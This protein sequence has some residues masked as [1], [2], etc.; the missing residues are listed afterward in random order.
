MRKRILF[1]TFGLLLIS[2]NAFADGSCNLAGSSNAGGIYLNNVLTGSGTDDSPYFFAN[3]GRKLYFGTNGNSATPFMMIDTSGNVGIGT[4]SPASKLDVNGDIHVSGNVGIGTITAGQLSVAGIIQSTSGG[5][6]FPDG[7]TQT[8]ANFVIC[9]KV[10][11][12]S[13][14]MTVNATTNIGYALFGGGGGGGGASSG[15]GGGGGGGSTAILDNGTLIQYAAGG[16]GGYS[17]GYNSSRNGSAGMQVYGNYSV[18]S[19]HTLTIYVGGGYNC[20][21]G[22]GS[23]GGVGGSGTYGNGGGGGSYGSGGGGGAG[24]S[25]SV[26]GGSGGVG[27]G[28]GVSSSGSGGFGSGYGQGGIGN[29]SGGDGGSVILTYQ[30][31]SCSNSITT[32][33]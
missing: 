33:P 7:T 22:G 25:A 23:A 26:A 32:L 20:T 28:H 27:G 5:F 31:T 3:T 18:L 1:F 30:A 4:T 2:F 15:Y 6:K 12:S 8:T 19:G 16:S 13:A 9:T 10:I 11:N 24:S 21:A 14:T 29:G 17:S